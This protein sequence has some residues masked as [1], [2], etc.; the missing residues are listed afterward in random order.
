MRLTVGVRIYPYTEI[1]RRAVAEGMTAPSDDLL[2]PKFYIVPGMSDWLHDTV[3][4][5]CAP[6]PTWFN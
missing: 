2:R 3:A 4:A 6:R 5:W 1:A